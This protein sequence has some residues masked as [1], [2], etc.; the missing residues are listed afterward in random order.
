LRITLYKSLPARKENN[1]LINQGA[2][3]GD[4]VSREAEHIYWIIK[5]RVKNPVKA[6]ISCL[7]IS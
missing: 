7:Y 3:T 6:E 1:Q 4:Q 5:C 2:D